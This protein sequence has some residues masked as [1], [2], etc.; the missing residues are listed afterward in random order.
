MLVGVVDRRRHQLRRLAAGIAEH[1]AL[2]AGAF[3]LVAG[4]VDALGDVGRLGV[5]Q[6]LDVAVFPVEAGLLVADV[7][8]REA[9]DVGDVVLGDR[10]GAAGLAGD[11]D[12]VGGGERLA[13]DADVPG[14]DAVLGADLKN[15]STISS[16]IRSQTLSGW[17]SERIRW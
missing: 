1:D 5:Q 8:D 11:D 14:I 10:G 6:D 15:R 16:E 3:V 7:P 13:G 9:G 4:G 17:P 2:V 12:A